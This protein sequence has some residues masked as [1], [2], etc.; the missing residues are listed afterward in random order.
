MPKALFTIMFCYFQISK[1]IETL[2]KQLSDKGTEI[3]A[4]MGKHNLQVRRTRPLDFYELKKEP[5]LS[6]GVR[7]GF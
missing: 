3:N 7:P 6:L 2:E 4:Y 5:G 1:L